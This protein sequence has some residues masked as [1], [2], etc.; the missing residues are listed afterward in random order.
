MRITSC[1]MTDVGLKRVH[2]E[3]NFLINEEVGVYV[4]CDGMGGHAGGE[5][6]SAIA[7]HTI[8]ESF[9]LMSL[10]NQSVEGMDEVISQHI[11]SIVQLAGKTIFE[12]AK[13]ERRYRGMGTTC[14]MTYVHD[15]KGYIAHVGDS[16]GYLLRKNRIEQLTEDHS[17]VNERIRAGY[18]TVEEAKNFRLKNVITRSLG[19]EN[20]VEVDIQ[21]V[22]LEVGDIL[23]MCSD[24][25]CNLV[26]AEQMARVM[27]ENPLQQATR[28]LIHM[29]CDA[30]G[31]DNITVVMFRVDEL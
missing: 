11:T 23:M 7:V 16:R 12:E 15:G 31:D 26:E 6:A 18:L 21:I 1:G 22:P 13:R 30:G 25:L 27:L 9:S 10:E 19:F 8:D 17:L 3:D 24:G 14:V 29:A 4:V 5:I 20:E 28:T 2:N